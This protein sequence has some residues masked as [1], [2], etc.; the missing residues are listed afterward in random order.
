M[1]PREGRY[2]G[3]DQ[4]DV[5]RGQKKAIDE[6]QKKVDELTKVHGTG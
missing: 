6:A 4:R 2:S 1:M 5:R 3:S